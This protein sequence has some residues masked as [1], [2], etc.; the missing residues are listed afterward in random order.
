MS[1]DIPAPENVPMHARAEIRWLARSMRGLLALDEL[2]G[3]TGEI[4]QLCRD[5]RLKLDVLKGEEQAAR[6]RIADCEREC[7]EKIVAARGEAEGIVSEARG[8]RA[9]AQDIQQRAEAALAQAS[10]GAYGIRAAA[11]AAAAK[12]ADTTKASLADVEAAIAAATAQLADV[13]TQRAAA[14]GE[15]DELNAHISAGKARFR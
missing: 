14:Q 7:A 13:E 8:V 9:S 2:L 12:L 15:L 5:V 1:A 3:E 6:D 4:E 10:I 11:E